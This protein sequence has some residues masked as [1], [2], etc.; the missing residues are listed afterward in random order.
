MRKPK[1]NRCDIICS[2]RRIAGKDDIMTNAEIVEVEMDNMHRAYQRGL[3][4][5]LEKVNDALKGNDLEEAK[6]LI[7]ELIEDT[8][9]DISE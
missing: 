4:R 5:H 1:N 2:K 7:C 8:K 9:A 3:L 6:K